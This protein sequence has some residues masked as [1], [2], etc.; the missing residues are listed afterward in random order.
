MLVGAP[1]RSVTGEVAH[2]HAQQRP[3]DQDAH[4]EGAAVHDVRDQP[5]EE[6]VLRLTRPGRE[7]SRDGEPKKS[8][9][10]LLQ[11]LAPD[12]PV[13]S[14]NRP[15]DDC[16]DQRRS[17]IPPGDDVHGDEHNGGQAAVHHSSPTADRPL[18]NEPLR[19]QLVADQRVCGHGGLGWALVG[20]G[21]VR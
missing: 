4:N 17:Q 2:R 5:G 3:P 11:A 9:Q 16:C 6:E 10:H 8:G 15:G 12:E 1:T 14:K 13:D 21:L 19:A 7:A 20:R 18:E